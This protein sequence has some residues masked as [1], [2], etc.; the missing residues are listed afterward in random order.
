MFNGQ[1]DHYRE[2]EVAN[3]ETDAL[4]LVIRYVE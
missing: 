4:A 2:N 3:H 1:I